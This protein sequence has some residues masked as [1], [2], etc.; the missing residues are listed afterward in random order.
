MKSSD[1]DQAPWYRY[2]WPWFAIGIIASGVVG[3]IVT[4]VIATQNPPILIRDD[5]GRFGQVQEQKDTRE[6]RSEP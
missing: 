2:F 6:Q 3:G 5:I 4:I 1:K